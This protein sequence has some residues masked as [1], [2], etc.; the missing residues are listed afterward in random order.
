M[1]SALGSI[2][3]WQC[4]EKL[5][6]TF[7]KIMGNVFQNHE[8]CF[9]KLRAVFF[10]DM[11]HTLLAFL[12]ASTDLFTNNNKVSNLPVVFSLLGAF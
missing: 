3:H 12:L 8:Q 6:A 9:S 2:K 7:E 1:E 11:S 4:F 10:E 5:W